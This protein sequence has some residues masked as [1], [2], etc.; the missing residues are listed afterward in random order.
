MDDRSAEAAQRPELLQVV[1]AAVDDDVAPDFG[2]GTERS[3][4]H[5]LFV[6]RRAVD[7]PDVL[8]T[9][10]ERRVRRHACHHPALTVD[11]QQRGGRPAE[12]LGCASQHW[13]GGVEQGIGGRDVRQD[14]LGSVVGEQ[15]G[16]LDPP[17]RGGDHVTVWQGG[18]HVSTVAW[19]TPDVEGSPVSTSRARVPS[20]RRL[21]WS[22]CVLRLGM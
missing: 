21:R 5:R 14:G 3:G 18:R 19:I 12:H 9:P 1:L 7:R 6:E 17:P 10:F 13:A 4:S 8:E 2:G 22:A 11:E 20:D 16:R 15:P